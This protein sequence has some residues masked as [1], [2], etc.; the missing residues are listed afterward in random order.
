MVSL[1]EFGAVRQAR[2]GAVRRVMVRFGDAGKVWRDG[3]A[4]WKG[5]RG[6][7]RCKARRGKACGNRRDVNVDRFPVML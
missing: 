3:Y 5:R 4:A 2:H 6:K 7:S 1:G